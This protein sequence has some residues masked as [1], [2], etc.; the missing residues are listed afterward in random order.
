[1]PRTLLGFTLLILLFLLSGCITRVVQ[2]QPWPVPDGKYDSEYPH[3]P[4]SKALEELLETV[5]FL[6]C[7]AYYRGYVFSPDSRLK[8]HQ[9][10][11]AVI[12]ANAVQQ[13]FFNH[14]AS[15]TATVVYAQDVQLALLTCAHIV[16]FPDTLFT[17]RTD[18]FDQPTEYLESIAIKIR[19]QNYIPDLPLA[20]DLKILVSDRSLDVALVG[21]TLPR[22]PLK[23]I[24]VF[25]F[26]VGSARELQWG[27][28]VYILGFPKGQKMVTSGLVSSPNRTAQG[29]FLVDAPFNKGFSGGIVV[30][31]RDGIPNFELV[32]LMNSV[33]AESELILVPEKGVLKKRLVEEKPYRGDVYVRNLRRIN[34]GVTYAIG[35]DA[36]REFIFANRE[37][38]QEMGYDFSLFFESPLP[39][40]TPPGQTKRK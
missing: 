5:H 1:M 15:G 23:P 11:E 25:D 34:Y 3:Q 40:I 2:T 10:T 27:T 7:V 18:A 30:A 39:R 33:S 14:T 8:R 20:N 26:P 28:F 6:N 24:R 31:I 32:G 21:Q 13:T 36:I 4:A 38:L 22:P 9:L 35:I 17:F 29:S 19:Q 37:R 12:K 16:D